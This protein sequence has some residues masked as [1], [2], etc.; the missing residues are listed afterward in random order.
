MDFQDLIL[1]YLS[2]RLQIVPVF[3]NLLRYALRRG[4]K[5]PAQHRNPALVFGIHNIIF[6]HGLLIK[7]IRADFFPD[8][9]LKGAVSKQNISG[10]F[11]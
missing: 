5:L 8:L 1:Y 11:V 7:G 6:F 10:H 2:L 9:F 4:F 3:L